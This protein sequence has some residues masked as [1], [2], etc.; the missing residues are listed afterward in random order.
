MVAH[1]STSTSKAERYPLPE[2]GPLMARLRVPDALRVALGGGS[3][4]S[5]QR[6]IKTLLDGMGL[7]W[8]HT[9]NEAK[10]NDA[11]QGSALARGLKRG[12]PDVLIYDPFRHG[13]RGR[14]VGLAIEL[15]RSDE[16][17]AAVSDDQRRWLT[18]L[19]ACGW[20]AEWCRGFLEASK[21]ITACYGQ[22]AG[23]G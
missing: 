18:E 22:R 13:D 23:R 19:R 6:R 11:E 12:V 4:D 8:Q 16:T 17:A 10:R 14:C 7:L 21:L 5:D 2:D 1:T 9:P 15:K 3:E 20:M